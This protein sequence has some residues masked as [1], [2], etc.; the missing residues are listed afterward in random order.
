[1]SPR[2]LMVISLFAPCVG[3]AEVQ[4]G[5]IAGALQRRGL[6]VAVLTRRLAGLPVVDRIA[7]IEI[8]RRIRVVRVRHLFGLTFFLSSL[9][10]LWRQRR[11]YDVG[12]VRWWTRRPVIVTGLSTGSGSDFAVLRN[13]LG[14]RMW[15]A[16]ARRADRVVVL[17]D[18]SRREALRAGV[19][20]Q[21]LALIPN[22]VDTRQ[23][24]PARRQ[25]L[26]GRIVCVGR[27]VPVKGFD[28]LLDA[29]ARLPAD[30]PGWTLEFAGDGPERDRLAARAA[31][32]G[33]GSR[34]TFCGLQQDVAPLL[35]RAALFVLPSR[36][37]GMPNAL[38]E[39]MAS[40]C[41]VIATRVGAVADMLQ[42]DRNG[43]L[44]PPGDA[45]A[46][47]RQLHRLLC[48]PQE[49]CRLGN[50][51]AATA[52]ETYALEHVAARYARLYAEVAASGA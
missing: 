48:A 39:A 32:L 13:T 4:A 1:M 22:G 45:D 12:L 9:W 30:C 51:A 24:T 34:V 20:P 49:A 41:A 33:L 52:G 15:L 25:P 29:L 27:L 28:V 46:L 6:S 10:Q 47:A 50:A 16:L 11:H 8:A 21:R 2:V 23:F 18:V 40:G 7:G 31:E 17:G 14:G 3:G 44:V 26:P 37:E 42:H 38:L 5:R 35:A 43:L 36:Y 19:C